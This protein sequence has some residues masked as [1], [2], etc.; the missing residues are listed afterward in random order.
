MG[1]VSRMPV[2]KDKVIIIKSVNYREVDKILT[3][4]GKNFGK[5]PLLAKG[6]RKIDSK[7]RGNTQTLS[8]SSISFYRNRGMGVLIESK[9]V[10]APE[11]SSV[12][13]KGIERVLSLF[14]KFVEED[15]TSYDFYEKL[16]F[17]L[18]NGFKD[19][20][21]NKFR[22]VFLKNMGLLS[23][24][25]CTKCEK[26]DEIAYINLVN[27]EIFCKKCYGNI[28]IN[29]GMDLIEVDKIDYLSNKLTISI[30]NYIRKI[31]D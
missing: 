15:D 20:D 16:L 19:S 12:N 4:V 7:N 24:S 28:D 11:Y 30:D 22:L 29:Q 21:V 5:F 31:F 6:I 18:K 10:F 25:S 1:F 17:V 26:T 3:V 23:Y 8:V 13:L 14:N 27:F 2:L 9:S